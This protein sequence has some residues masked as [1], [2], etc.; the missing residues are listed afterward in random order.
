[1]RREPTDSPP[2]DLPFIIELWRQDRRE[3]IERILARA[4]NARLAREI[5]KAAVG[6]YPDRRITLRNGDDLIADAG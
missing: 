1:M 2:E 5:H 3:E 4:G 6:E